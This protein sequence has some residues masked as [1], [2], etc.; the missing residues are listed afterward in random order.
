MSP[1]KKP[2]VEDI[3]FLKEETLIQ[4][5][6]SFHVQIINPQK[7]F[8]NFNLSQAQQLYEWIIKPFEANLQAEKI[9]TILF[10]LG[11]GLRT[12]PIAALHDG[13]QF[14]VEK[15]SLAIIPAFNLIDSNYTPIEKAR[16]LAMGASE[17]EKQTPLPAVPVEL[18]TIVD[19]NL[20]EN[21]SPQNISG[22]WPG[23]LFL[24]QEFTLENLKNQLYSQS[25]NIIHLATHAEF[26]PGKPENSYI[27]FWDTKLNLDEVKEISWNTPPAELLVLSAC[28]TAVG[29]K[30]VE[31]GFA[32]LA[33]EAGVQSVLASL[34]YVNDIG[35]LALMSEFYE[36]LKT[37]PSKDEAMR[38]TQIKM[39]QGDVLLRNQR[40]K[41][42]RGEISLPNY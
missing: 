42:S 15:Y 28:K 33:L 27:Q 37:A 9:D 8:A 35:T 18:S 16:I 29:N 19:G 20:T 41:F 34:W 26:R 36:Q 6:K 14:L 38:Q 1:G 5:V 31:L 30:D 22:G 32:G 13:E 25:F 4:T 40:L 7:G 12:L 24:N 2:L 39:I 10:C 11:K 23:E 21:I 17:F 3:N